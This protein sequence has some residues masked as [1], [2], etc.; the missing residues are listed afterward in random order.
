MT[1]QT[2]QGILSAAAD[3][4]ERTG[5]TQEYFAR[6]KN[7]LACDMLSDDAV[8]FCIRGAIGAVTFSHPH[9][10]SE[11]GETAQ[12][13]VA[14]RVGLKYSCEIGKWNN[15]PLRTKEEV[16]AALRGASND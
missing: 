11:I 1:D 13:M 3:L 8:C 6:Q 16:I 7:G 9:A 4:I 12:R 10:Y 14:D 5:W 2:P 15:H